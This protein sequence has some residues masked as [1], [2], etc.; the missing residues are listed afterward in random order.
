M[1]PSTLHQ[2]V[3]A[4]ML[5]IEVVAPDAEHPIG[6]AFAH[7]EPRGELDSAE[8]PS[9]GI[10]YHPAPVVRVHGAGDARPTE[11]HVEKLDGV[12][13]IMLAQ[14]EISVGIAERPHER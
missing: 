11:Y 1:R 2:A 13:P 7:L 9:V 14:P 3:Q 4:H 6:S 8:Q 10:Q 5:D 12:G